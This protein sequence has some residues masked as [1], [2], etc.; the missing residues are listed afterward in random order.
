MTVTWNQSECLKCT[1]VISQLL[2][3]LTASRDRSPLS[4]MVLGPVR[5]RLHKKQQVM[6]SNIINRMT[7]MQC[8]DENLLNH[9]YEV[10]RI[11]KSALYSKFY[12][13]KFYIKKGGGFIAHLK[14]V[15]LEILNYKF[16]REYL[17]H[18]QPLPPHLQRSENKISSPL[19]LTWTSSCTP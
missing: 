5:L 9:L 4:L 10:E 7:S 13:T 15:V 16:M 3:K 18:R 11:L 17:K 2:S 19:N 6:R 8:L 1:S 12:N 14:R